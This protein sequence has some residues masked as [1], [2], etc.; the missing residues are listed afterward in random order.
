MGRSFSNYGGCVDTWGP[1]VAVPSA[2]ATNDSDYGTWDGTS[3]AAPHMTGRVANLLYVNPTL[4]LQGVM[5]ILNNATFPISTGAGLSLLSSPLSL[6]WCRVGRLRRQRLP[7][8]PVHVRRERPHRRA[9]PG[10]LLRKKSPCFATLA[11]GEQR[12]R[13]ADAGPVPAVLGGG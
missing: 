12:P 6:F 5:F 2:I 3:M 1:G 8:A 9:R 13:R 4:D 11:G 7:V 10:R